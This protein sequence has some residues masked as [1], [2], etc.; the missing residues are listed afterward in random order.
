[1]RGLPAGSLPDFRNP[2]FL[3][4]E[5]LYLRLPGRAK[6]AQRANHVPPTQ[7][8][9]A[10]RPSLE[11][12]RPMTDRRIERVTIIV[13]AAV[14]ALSMSLVAFRTQRQFGLEETGL[15]NAPYTFA[16]YG[17]LAFPVYGYWYEAAYDRLFVHPPTHYLVVGLLLKLGVGLY[18]AE[19]IPVLFFI[20]LSIY[21]IARSLLPFR[22]QLGLLLGY[23]AG[24]G[25]CSTLGIGDYFFHLRPDAHAATAWF[26][27]LLLLDD[28]RQ[29]NWPPTTL[30][31]GAL[32]L[33]YASTVHYFALLGF[34]GAVV[35]LAF[36][37]RQLPRARLLA[38]AAAVAA[39]GLV[40][41]V[42]YLYRFVLYNLTELLF[43]NA[44]Y[45]AQGDWFSILE[46]NFSIYPGMVA[47]LGSHAPL[48]YAL[49][50]KSALALSI[51]PFAAAA[52]ML[53]LFRDLRPLVI[54]ALPLPLFIFFY[55]PRKLFSYLY[56]EIFLFLC[57]FW[58]LL[59][60]AALWTSGRY[61]GGRVRRY[62]G[63]ALAACFLIA[64][65]VRTP[66]VRQIRFLEPVPPHGMTVARAAALEIVGPHA[67]VASQ[68]S[69]WY[70]GGAQF[71]VDLTK[72]IFWKLPRWDLKAYFSRL[73]AVAVVSESFV[74][75]TTGLNEVS[76]YDEGIVHLLGFFAAQDFSYPGWCW[77]TADAS[78]QVQSFFPLRGKLHRFVQDPDGGYS[79]LAV[80]GRVQPG[81]AG[82]IQSMP[83]LTTSLV[84]YLPNDEEPGQR[85]VV[86]LLA[87]AANKAAVAAGLPSQMTIRE[88]ISGRVDPVD[89]GALVRNLS[90]DEFI[91][92][93]RSYEE[94]IAEAWVNRHSDGPSDGEPIVWEKVY[95]EAQV[96]ATNSPVVETRVESEIAPFWLLRSQS[97]DARQGRHYLL[98]HDLRINR[99]G[100]GIHVMQQGSDEPLLSIRRSCCQDFTTESVVFSPA[101]D[102]R[103]H[104]AVTAQPAPLARGRVEAL[105]KNSRIREIDLDR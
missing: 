76:L 2:H 60:V 16:H 79:L 27:G 71:W 19:A 3:R 54:A 22:L 40:V 42:P 20:L 78:R 59:A 31:A 12:F 66:A 72:D 11:E 85:A 49:P 18:Y 89:V 96:V 102:A 86:L 101:E 56:P 62:T 100:V 14:L 33:T 17:K 69:L 68:H 63:P 29:R 82:R 10:D 83:S 34:L 24:V 88:T 93:P 55:S 47:A 13:C 7:R 53:L 92:F 81:E 98:R 28:A 104:L 5:V 4:S 50:L 35:Y 30:F 90:D 77:F 65:V 52:V 61:L 37:A 91:R 74:N 48:L 39:G 87:A 8:S 67:T 6:P 73:T 36:A 95:S 15:L 97:F 51:P 58:I 80:S 46:R 99:G 38:A 103:L 9:A 26:A 21:L 44:A 32:V 105:F 64:F 23:G 70:V 75:S 1:M 43:L 84:L 94:A 45:Q 41:G 25:V 57:G